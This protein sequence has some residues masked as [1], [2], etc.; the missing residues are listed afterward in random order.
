MNTNEIKKQIA[1]LGHYTISLCPEKIYINHQKTNK[2]ICI[3]REDFTIGEVSDFNAVL[4]TK[5]YNVTQADSIIGIFNY[6]KYNKYL[7]VVSSSIIAAK[8]KEDY[9]YNINSINYIKINY[10]EKSPEEEK[11][12]KLTLLK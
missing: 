5:Y 7:L 11:R 12:N 4:N 8:F 2:V 6:D 10:Q 9:I 1:T 3:N